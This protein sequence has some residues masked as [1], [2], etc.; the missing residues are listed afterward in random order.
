MQPARRRLPL[1]RARQQPRA[2]SSRRH[3]PRQ[4]RRPATGLQ[5]ARRRIMGSASH[6]SGRSRL[7]IWTWPLTHRVSFTACA[8]VFLER[9]TR[10]DVLS[11]CA[12]V[13]RFYEHLPYSLILSDAME[14]VGMDAEVFGRL[15]F[16]EYLN[17]MEVGIRFISVC[18]VADIA[19]NIKLSACAGWR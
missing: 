19:C 9:A 11:I 8:G 4:S 10:R 17:M 7:W 13:P 3:P 2:R 16:W 18:F 6:G 5:R 14:Q 1:Q 15:Q 12:Q